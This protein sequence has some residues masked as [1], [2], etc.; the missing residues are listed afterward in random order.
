MVSTSV[1]LCN[2]LIMPWLPH[3][4]VKA[5]QIPVID[6]PNDPGLGK[7]AKKPVVPTG[8]ANPG[9]PFVIPSDASNDLKKARLAG[10]KLLNVITEMKPLI[11]STQKRNTQYK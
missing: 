2:G 9:K 10:E 6:L 7:Q 4:Q 3:D 5:L 11:S 8:N 1:A